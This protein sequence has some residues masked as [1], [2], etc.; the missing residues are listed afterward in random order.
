MDFC[1]ALIS[2]TKSG[3]E[4]LAS[5]P[6]ADTAEV[7]S[8]LKANNRDAYFD[9]VTDVYRADVDNDGLPDNLAATIEGSAQRIGFEIYDQQW[10]TRRYDWSG[11]PEDED[12][13]WSEFDHLARYGGTTYVVWHSGSARL[14]SHVSKFS[15][16]RHQLVC[17]YA[18]SDQVTTTITDATDA[19]LCRAVLGGAVSY[20]EFSESNEL[21]L[22][23]CYESG[24]PDCARAGF[25]ALVDIDNDGVTDNVVKMTVAY[26]GRRGCD[27]TFLAL[28]N[29]K[30]DQL[31][32]TAKAEALMGATR[33][34]GICGGATSTIFKYGSRWYVENKY[35]ARNVFDYHEVLLFQGDRST[36]ACRFS[37]GRALHVVQ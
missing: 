1:R 17:R 3:I 11:Y 32:D 24:G 5:L 14:L 9:N 13:R 34:W 16:G 2:P 37:V 28:I 12:I 8:R 22:N 7:W 26:G 35:P 21:P 27:F 15:E 31:D 23:Q 18:Y 20:A 33:K 10:K 30:G 19:E 4:R 6:D 29:K 36:H 25:S